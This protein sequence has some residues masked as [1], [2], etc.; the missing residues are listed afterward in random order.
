MR[1]A[2]L[3]SRRGRR[4]GGGCGRSDAPVGRRA[5]SAQ[6]TGERRI[7]HRRGVRE[8]RAGRAWCTRRR[9]GRWWPG[10]ARA[11]RAARRRRGSRPRTAAGTRSPR[12]RPGSGA[13]RAARP[14]GGRCRPRGSARRSPGR[15][16]PGERG[17]P[18]LRRA[19]GPAAASTAGP[20]RSSIRWAANPSTACSPRVR[21]EVAQR[22]DG[23]V[24]VAVPEPGP[25]GVGEQVV[26]GRAAPTA[27]A[28]ARSVAHL[29]LARL[30]QRVQVPADRGRRQLQLGR[31]RSRGARPLLHQQAGDGGAGAT[32]GMARLGTGPCRDRR[33]PRHPGP[34]VRGPGP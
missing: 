5:R 8:P 4:D 13:G 2:S 28:A 25:A 11:C 26:P 27:G 30:D 15:P 7:G 29:R 6:G 12:G 33:P 21:G 18:V 24:V 14:G 22:R 32:L 17:D 23:Q 34:G 9:R 16:A 1:T 19:D 3:S 31:H 10:A 20:S